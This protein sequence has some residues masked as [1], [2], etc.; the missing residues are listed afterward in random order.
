MDYELNISS[1]K[2]GRALRLTRN[3]SRGVCGRA[4]IIAGPPSRYRALHLASERTP[5]GQLSLFVVMSMTT[6]S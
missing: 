6:T 4:F 1:Y 2:H 3:P 5:L